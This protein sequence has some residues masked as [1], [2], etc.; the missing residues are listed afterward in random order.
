MP[1][2]STS[3]QVITNQGEFWC[4]G[5]SYFVDGGVGGEG[6]GGQNLR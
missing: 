4:G 5:F 2:M 3:P 6:S 1:E